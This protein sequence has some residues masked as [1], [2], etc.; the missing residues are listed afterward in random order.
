MQLL[1]NPR[2]GTY[3]FTFCMRL[4]GGKQVGNAGWDKF[5]RS[6]GLARFMWDL[7][8]LPISGYGFHMCATGADPLCAGTGTYRDL[9]LPRDHACSQ[10]LPSGNPTAGGSVIQVS[11]SLPTKSAAQAYVAVKKPCRCEPHNLST[12]IRMCFLA[13]LVGLAACETTGLGGAPSGIT[14]NIA[15]DTIRI[16]APAGFCIDPK[17]TNVDT[18]GA[19][20]LLS[21]CELITPTKAVRGNVVGMALTASISPNTASGEDDATVLSMRELKAY[22]STTEGRALLSRSGDARS[23]RIL[24]TVEQDDVL[25]VLIEDNGVQQVPGVEPRFWRAF[26]ELGDRFVVLSV[27][28]FKGAE[29]SAQDSLNLIASL[30][31]SLRRSNPG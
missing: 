21:D 7:R 16:V 31:A 8:S 13:L 3:A 23:V 18:G 12:A 28:E 29:I 17:S 19:F 22:S 27:L 11:R 25:Y 2:L 24:N 26:L 15:G 4:P 30:A 1:E 20:V 14:V 5:A 6:E 9:R 10:R